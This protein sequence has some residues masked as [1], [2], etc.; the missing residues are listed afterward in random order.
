MISRNKSQKGRIG[1]AYHIEKTHKQIKVDC[2]HY[3]VD[4]GSCYA[5]SIILSSIWDMASSYSANPPNTDR[6]ALV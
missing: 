4:D 5:R 2:E 1:T 3:D 6:R